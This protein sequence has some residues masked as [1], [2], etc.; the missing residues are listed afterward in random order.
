M[1]YEPENTLAAIRKAIALGVRFV[2]IDV[3]YVDGRLLVFHDH[4]LERTTNG[5]GYLSEQSFDNLR[6]LDAGGGQCIPTLEEVLDEIGNKSVS[7]N[8]ELRAVGATGPVA[9]CIENYISN[10]WDSDRFLVSSFNHRE[11]V[12]IR[13]LNPELKLGA[14]LCGLPVDDCRFAVELDAYSVHLCL[15]F[16]DRRAVEDAHDRGLKVFVYTVNEPDDMRMMRELGVDGVFTNYPDR[17]MCL[18][19]AD[20][21]VSRW[22]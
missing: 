7:V 6:K 14:L 19:T 4:R 12:K 8:I 13:Q 15:D 18:S 22:V 9:S 11:L 10:G 17:A 21:A 1:G 20:G 16:I 2:E 3:F 5:N